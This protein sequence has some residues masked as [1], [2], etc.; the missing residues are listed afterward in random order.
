VVVFCLAFVNFTVEYW[1]VFPYQYSA[2]SHFGYAALIDDIQK[3]MRQFDHVIVSSKINDSKQ[4]IYYLFYTKYEPSLFQSGMGIE[5]VL[6]PNGWVRVKRIGS[7]EFLSLLPACDELVGQ[8]VLLIGAPQ[9]FPKDMP[10]VVPVTGIP[11][12]FTVKDLAGHI[13]FKGVDSTKLYPR[14]SKCPALSQP[15]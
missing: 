3:N 10:G 2:Y 13:L 11:T 5:K 15:L 7:I 1:S 12:E 8:H 4:Y 6:E 14:T 9:E